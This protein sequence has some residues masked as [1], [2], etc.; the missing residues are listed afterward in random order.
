VTNG[1]FKLEAAIENWVTGRVADHITTYGGSRTFDSTTLR[2]S[3]DMPEDDDAE[4]LVVDSDGVEY[5]LDVEVFLHPRRRPPI[6]EPS[7]DQ[8][9]LLEGT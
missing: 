5:T 1:V 8:L 7:G 2:W 6:P 3:D 4:F 9:S